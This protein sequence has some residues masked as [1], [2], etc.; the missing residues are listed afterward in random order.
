MKLLESFVIINTTFLSNILSL[1]VDDHQKDR[2]SFRHRVI[3]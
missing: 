3:H 2:H 1:A